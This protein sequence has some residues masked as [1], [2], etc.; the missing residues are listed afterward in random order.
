[1]IK[2]I[3]I[4]AMCAALLTACGRGRAAEPPEPPRP[5]ELNAGAP[6]GSD[7]AVSRGI[8]AAEEDGEAEFVSKWEKNPKEA[9][10]DLNGAAG[11]DMVELDYADLKR[12]I[13]HGYFGMF[14]YDLESGK[15][16]RSLDLKEI[17][18]GDTQGDNFAL[19]RVSDDGKW[20]YIHA[21]G[22]DRAYTWNLSGD[23]KSDGSLTNN[24]YEES[25]PSEGFKVFYGGEYHNVKPF[26]NFVT[27]TQEHAAETLPE[28]LQKAMEG[29]EGA[30]SRRAALTANGTGVLKDSDGTIGGLLYVAY[31]SEESGGGL[32]RE[33]FQTIVNKN[34]GGTAE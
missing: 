14:V 6:D 25:D 19:V 10:Y 12:V 23:E 18:C 8:Y 31:G 15:I 2:K 21:N 3:V 11:A 13:F 9:E 32:A 7:G 26:D 1:M 27:L 5:A 24:A 16:T 34:S 22:S 28:P 17:G 4:P 29:N 20:V 30:F 33:L